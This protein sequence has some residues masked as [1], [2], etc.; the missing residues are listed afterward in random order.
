MPLIACAV[1]P[2]TPNGNA[3]VFKEEGVHIYKKHYASAFY[4]NGMVVLW[5]VVHILK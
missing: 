4:N 3:T 2:E 1:K 5:G